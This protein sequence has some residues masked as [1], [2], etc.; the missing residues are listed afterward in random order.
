MAAFVLSGFEFIYD[1][2]GKYDKFL[3]TL[4]DYSFELFII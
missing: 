4:L 1:I 3:V 2:E